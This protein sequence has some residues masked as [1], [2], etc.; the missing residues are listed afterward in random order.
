MH[1]LDREL[2]TQADPRHLERS[3]NYAPGPPLISWTRFAIDL[4]RSSP[5]DSPKV[6]LI[7]E[8][9]AVQ[10]FPNTHTRLYRYYLSL[11]STS[12]C[13]PDVLG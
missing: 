11:D 1:S 7:T 10:S 3:H 13:Y 9:A 5:P 4:N 12:K 2:H 8:L 6:A